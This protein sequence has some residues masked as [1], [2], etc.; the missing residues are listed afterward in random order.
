MTLRN[1]LIAGS[2]AIVLAGCSSGAS[3]SSGNAT[4]QADVLALTQA[5]AAR[6][7][8]AADTAMS[9]LRSDLAAEL[10]AG[11]VSAAR[12]AGIRTDLAAVAADVSAQRST[13]APSPT[14]TPKPQP[15][16]AP[17]KTHDRH[18]HGAGEGGDGGD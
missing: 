3:T 1:A 4:L 16:P 14:K 15:K 2:A 6:N 13:P 8:P 7:W 18:G 5:A 12:A 10:A 11:R 17:P 9:R